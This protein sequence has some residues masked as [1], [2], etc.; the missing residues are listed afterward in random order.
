M[1]H[2][3]DIVHKHNKLRSILIEYGCEEYGDSIID[4]ICELFNYPKTE[5]EE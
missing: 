4:D 3:N 2:I 5:V 1:I